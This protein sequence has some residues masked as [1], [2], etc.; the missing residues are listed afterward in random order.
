MA[1][2]FWADTDAPGVNARET[3]EVETPARIAT[4]RSVTGV[5]RL[6]VAGSSPK[7]D[8][9]LLVLLSGSSLASAASY[10]NRLQPGGLPGLAGTRLDG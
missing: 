8:A 2:R 4:S 9:V 1:A 7:A 6:M 3:A 10:G 5:E